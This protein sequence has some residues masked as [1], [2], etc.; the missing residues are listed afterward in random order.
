MNPDFPARIFSLVAAALF[1]LA[2]AAAGLT[3]DIDETQD[4]K[5][6]SLTVSRTDTNR[7]ELPET[8]INAFSSNESMD[9]KII[10]RSALVRTENPAELIILTEKRRLTLLLAPEDVP[11]RTLIITARKAPPAGSGHR[12]EGTGGM[13]PLPYEKAIT[14]LVVSLASGFAPGEKTPGEKHKLAGSLFLV[15]LRDAASPPFFA[16]LYV[17]RNA[18][19]RSAALTE[20]MF[21]GDPE[22]V[23]VGIDRDELLPGE[24]SQIFIVTKKEPSR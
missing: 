19:S 10:G 17:V 5:P 21:S 18:G 14:N 6:I 22:T 1:T 8:I 20:S 2:Q 4:S 15:H 9:V 13:E 7:I 16:S 12:A 3:I 23:A 24:S 11:S